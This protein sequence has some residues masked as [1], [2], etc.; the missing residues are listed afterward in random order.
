MT[1][2]I[3]S[4]NYPDNYGY[5][6]YKEYRITAP[7]YSEIKLFFDYFEVQYCA[8]CVCDSLTVKQFHYDCSENRTLRTR[9]F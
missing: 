1:G 2:T 3:V 7:P 5:N 9:Q 6:M 8:T 4:T